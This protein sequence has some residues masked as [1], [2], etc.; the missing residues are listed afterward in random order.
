M[1]PSLARFSLPKQ[2][3][4][5]LYVHQYAYIRTASLRTEHRTIIQYVCVYRWIAPRTMKH[6]QKF[7]L[8]KCSKNSTSLLLLQQPVFEI[9]IHLIGLNGAH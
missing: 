8:Q 1:Y 7:V 3:T 6:E 2:H 9:G 5:R 4:A